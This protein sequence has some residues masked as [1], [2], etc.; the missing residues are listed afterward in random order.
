NSGSGNENN[1]S[2]NENNGSGNENNGSG[3]ENNGSGDEN[4]GSGNENSGSGNENSGSGNENNGSGNGNNGSGNENN[5]SGNGNNGSWNSSYAAVKVEKGENGTYI[6]RLPG[7]NGLLSMRDSEVTVRMDCPE[8]I[9]EAGK[10][11]YAVFIDADGKLHAFRAEL[12]PG[13]RLCFRTNLSG[14]FVIVAFSSEQEEFSE[15]FYED[16]ENLPELALLR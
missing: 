7:E 12:E 10:P 3:N 4:S 2:G 1:G 5:G 15:A 8:E 16:M 11:I 14:R 9:R 6:L 13:G